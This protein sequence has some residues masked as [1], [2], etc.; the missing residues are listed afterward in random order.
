MAAALVRL[1]AGGGSAQALTVEVWGGDKPPNGTV[2]P[3]PGVPASVNGAQDPVLLIGAPVATFT[4]NG[5][6]NWRE[7]QLNNGDDHTKN[8]FGEFFTPA[9]IQARSAAPAV[10]TPTTPRDWRTFWLRP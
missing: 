9:D 7:N 5:P 3:S 8:L 6:I 2:N 10:N 4:Y 1:A